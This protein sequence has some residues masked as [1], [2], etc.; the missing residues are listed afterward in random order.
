FVIQDYAKQIYIR[1]LG[2]SLAAF[3]V[4]G[5]ISNPAIQ[6]FQGQTLLLENDDWQTTP[7]NAAIS[8]TGSPPLNPKDAALMT[9]LEPGNYTVVVRGVNNAT[10]VALIEINEVK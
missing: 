4:Q 9:Y 7:N 8:A 2:P 1:C 5:A 3:G 6:L 10:G